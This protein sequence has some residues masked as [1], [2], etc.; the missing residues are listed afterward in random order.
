MSL[1]YNYYGIGSP[2]RATVDSSLPEYSRKIA[3][4]ELIGIEVEVENV[5]ANL[6]P[7]ASCW[8]SKSDSSLRNQG[9][10]FVSLP[11][12]AC[13]APRA[14]ASLM[15]T[16]I[17]QGCCFSPRT[18]VHVH[19]N[20]AEDTSEVAA[21]VIMLYSVFERLFFKFVGRQRIKSIYCV[22]L[23]E[24]NL[25]TTIGQR[26]LRAD[27]WQKYASLNAKPLAEY[28]TLEF[29]HM[30]GTFNVEKLC[31]WIDMITQLKAFVL[32]VGTKYLRTLIAKLDDSFDFKGLL[33]EIFLH[34]AQ[35]LKYTSI[36]DVSFTYPIAKLCLT[37]QDSVRKLQAVATDNSIFYKLRNLS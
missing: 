31:I 15:S 24:T 28:G 5:S 2:K 4:E 9:V 13:D 16:T 35:Y 21:N 18:S 6:G 1:I 32:K 37:K 7:L 12:A 11:I 29:R 20:F 8:Q 14:L 25:L 10:E 19:L 22:P 3:S 27:A 33:D 30:H 23:T 26:G 36:K 17:G 34:N